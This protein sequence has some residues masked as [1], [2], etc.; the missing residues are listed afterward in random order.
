M[1]LGIEPMTSSLLGIQPQPPGYSHSSGKLYP[2]WLSLIKKKRDRG[3]KSTGNQSREALL[4]LQNES[5]FIMTMTQR[6]APETDTV[7]DVDR[8]GAHH[9]RGVLAFATTIY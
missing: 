8:V 4:L 1:V 2:K 5:G 3:K 9:A 7:M 6:M